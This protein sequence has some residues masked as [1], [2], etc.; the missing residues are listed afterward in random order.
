[1]KKQPFQPGS[2]GIIGHFEK[3]QWT[4]PRGDRAESLG[5]VEFDATDD[6]LQMRAAELRKVKDCD[7]TS[8]AIGQGHVDHDG[9]CE[10]RIE[11]AICEFF[12]V[13]DVADI[14]NGMLQNARKWLQ[15]QPAG[16]YRARISVTTYIDLPISAR[17]ISQVQRLALDTAKQRKIEGEIQFCTAEPLSSD[18]PT[19]S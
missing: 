13:S 17:H 19:E 6:I 1:M 12:K 11:S 18:K 9:P 16:N 15:S 7:E 2:S 14:T 5:E 10:V 3:Q 4:G 8:D